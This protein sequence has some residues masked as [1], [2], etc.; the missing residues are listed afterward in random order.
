[1]I[2]VLPPSKKKDF[3]WITDKKGLLNKSVTLWIKRKKKRLRK[4]KE[5][6]MPA[7]MISVLIESKIGLCVFWRPNV[8]TVTSSLLLLSEEER[9]AGEWTVI[10]CLLCAA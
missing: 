9:D 10:E 2:Y 3:R 7:M 6:I 5:V 8:P 4:T 1:M